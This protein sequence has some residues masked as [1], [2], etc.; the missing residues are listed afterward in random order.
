MSRLNTIPFRTLSVPRGPAGAS[1]KTVG[2]N[3]FGAGPRSGGGSKKG[4]AGKRAGLHGDRA[5]PGV[6]PKGPGSTPFTSVNL[7]ARRA[8]A[9]AAAAPTAR[10]SLLNRV[11]S[12]ARRAF[13]S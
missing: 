1:F 10:T 9:R 7:G 11:V 12:R 5:R 4:Y 6:H 2:G 8:F 13:G 3:S